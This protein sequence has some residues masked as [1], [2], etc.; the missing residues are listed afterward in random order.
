MTLTDFYNFTILAARE[1][2]FKNPKINI[3]SGIFNGEIKHSCQL[4]V[5]E[6]SKFVDSGLRDNPVSAIQS[7]KDA[8][9]FYNK[10]YS[11]M[12]EDIE[13]N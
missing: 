5:S 4:W 6:K 11:K 7:F 3:V 9:E 1:R 8:I 2:G 13:L 12:S 10:T